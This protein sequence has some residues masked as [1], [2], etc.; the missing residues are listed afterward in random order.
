MTL[1][2][3]SK[4]ENREKRMEIDKVE[5][6]NDIQMRC[7]N[8]SI[9]LSEPLWK[10]TFIQTGGIADI[11]AVPKDIEEARMIIQYAY[12]KKIPLTILGYGTNVI[13]RIK[14]FVGLSL[15]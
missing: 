9:M 12:E 1:F 14:V 5:L 13:I 4:S 7:K 11:Y 2:S 3:E 6:M 10:H 15:T 8:T